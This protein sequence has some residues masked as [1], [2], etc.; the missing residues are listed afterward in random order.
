[1]LQMQLRPKA[2][3]RPELLSS[4]CT[5]LAGLIC[6]LLPLHGYAKSPNS[7]ALAAAQLG[8]AAQSTKLAADHCEHPISPAK[9]ENLFFQSTPSSTLY[10]PSAEVGAAFG[11]STDL[12]H[13]HAVIGARSASDG[14]GR[15]YVVS[16][17]GGHWSNP[18]QELHADSLIDPLNFG[19]STAIDG[20]QIA[21][22]AKQ[23]RSST[24]G[25]STLFESGVVAF[26]RRSPAGWSQVD[27]LFSPAPSRGGAFGLSIDLQGDLAI[28]GEPGAKKGAQLRSGAAH[29]YRRNSAGKWQPFQR[30]EPPAAQNDAFFGSTVRLS[31]Y[32][33][34]T[35]AFVTALGGSGASKLNGGVYVFERPSPTQPFRLL[36]TL[37]PSSNAQGTRFGFALHAAQERLWVGAPGE[38][39]PRSGARVGAV[40]LFEAQAD[41][42]RLQQKLRPPGN[43]AETLFGV[44]LAAD[45]QQTVIASRPIDSGQSVHIYATGTSGSWQYQRSIEPEAAPQQGSPPDSLALHNTTLLVGMSQKEDP[46]GRSTG[47]VTAYRLQRVSAP[48]SGNIA[49]AGLGF[50]LSLLLA[51]VYRPGVRAGRRKMIAAG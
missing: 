23:A 41:G 19:W 4:R 18:P 33:R 26:F 34:S 42:W 2:K 3:T 13:E 43:G 32:G 45:A 10:A 31:Q 46:Q 8:R 28:I 51:A 44:A 11:A 37:S 48:L 16:L 9:A 40:Y 30:L 24:S 12:N 17:E 7:P 47:A 36:E 49:L 25:S 29:I 21:V 38:A 20:D 14:E 27:T 35:F 22:S 50:G 39:H 5:R 1:M 6:A 15:A